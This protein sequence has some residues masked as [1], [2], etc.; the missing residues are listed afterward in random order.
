MGEEDTV[1]RI[2]S[3]TVRVVSPGDTVKK[4]LDVMVRYEIGSV[5]L[6]EE[7]KAKGIVTERDIVKLLRKDGAK[8]LGIKVKDVASSP[9]VTVG[10]E[11]QVWEA[12]TVMLKKKI[13]RL[14]ILSG[15]KLVGITTERDLLKWVVGVTYEPNIPDEIKRLITQNP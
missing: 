6:A 10:P 3:K 12:F 5:V 9:L 14:P 2:M 1:G 7:G 4:A 11:T 13:R 8:V 15:G